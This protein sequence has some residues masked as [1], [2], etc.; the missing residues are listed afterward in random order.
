MRST[1]DS[2]LVRLFFS[3]PG[4]HRNGE[5]LGAVRL[6]NVRRGSYLRDLYTR[7]SRFVLEDDFRDDSRHKTEISL[8]RI[9]L[10]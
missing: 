10:T 3:L 4:W 2:F 9:F 5:E 1:N 6:C 8:Q 7:E